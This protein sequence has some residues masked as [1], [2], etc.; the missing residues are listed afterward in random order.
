MNRA[1][2]AP[3]NSD[4]SSVWSCRGRSLG[5]KKVVS[6]GRLDVRVKC[7]RGSIAF[8]EVRGMKGN[9]MSGRW[10]IQCGLTFYL[11]VSHLRQRVQSMNQ[12]P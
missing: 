12:V 7:N 11:T 10:S 6:I 1:S 3:K 2:K 8:D 9:S 5:S 4:S